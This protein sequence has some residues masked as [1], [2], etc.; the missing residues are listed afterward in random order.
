MPMGIPLAGIKKP[1]REK[2]LLVSYDCGW[3]ITIHFW[4]SLL[5]VDRNYFKLVPQ[6]CSE[7]ARSAHLTASN[8]T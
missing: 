8:F 4:K 6:A 1:F 2:A 3:S 7:R 5:M